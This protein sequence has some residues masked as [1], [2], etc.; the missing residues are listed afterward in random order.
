MPC[1]PAPPNGSTGFVVAELHVAARRTTTAPGRAAE[2]ARVHSRLPVVAADELRAAGVVRWEIWQ[3]GDHLFHRVESTRH[4]ADVIAELRSREP[5]DPDWA[6]LIATLL[7]S[8]PGADVMLPV[9]WGMDSNRQWDAY[10][11]S[12]SPGSSTK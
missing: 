9:V 5:A 7:S 8:E 10:R 11:S 2:Y 6:A 4:Y 12:D 1:S 3:D